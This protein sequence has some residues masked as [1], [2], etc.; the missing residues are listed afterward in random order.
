MKLG[1]LDWPRDS[2]VV[3]LFC[4]RGNGLK[5]LTALGFQSLSGVDLSETLLRT[6]EGPARLFLGD[7]REL[8]FPDR[9]INVVVVQG[10][11]HHLPEL[12]ADLENTLREIRRVLLPAGRLVMVE[13]WNTPFLRLVHWFCHRA[14]A[15]RF[16]GKL[17]ALSTMIERERATYE[18]WLARPQQILDLLQSHFI[19]EQQ[20][21]SW[22]K[23][24]FVGRPK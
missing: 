16:W 10:G 19:R 23:L 11:L 2:V 5:A 20:S 17:D 15:R 9:S 24:V 18:N 8:R 21:L 13:P 4:G 7:C 3:E 1:A 6:Y 14:M 12:P 22:G